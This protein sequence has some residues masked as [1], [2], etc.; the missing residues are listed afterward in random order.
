MNQHPVEVHDP[1]WIVAAAAFVFIS[2]ALVASPAIMVTGGAM[3]AV[4]LIVTAV[5]SLRRRLQVPPRP[6]ARAYPLR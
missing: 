6:V 1:S 5:S 2:G 3:L 4:S